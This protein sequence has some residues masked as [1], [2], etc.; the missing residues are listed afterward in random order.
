MTIGKADAASV[1]GAEA[2]RKPRFPPVTAHTS[3]RSTVLCQLSQRAE[4]DT[5][6]LYAAAPL[7]RV[8][9]RPMHTPAD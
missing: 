7:L 2:T 8:Y 6:E 4:S 3:K 1:A 9:P 5:E